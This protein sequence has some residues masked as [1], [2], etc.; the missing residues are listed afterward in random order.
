MK[1]DEEMRCTVHKYDLSGMNALN[2]D[3]CVNWLKNVKIVI[4]RT[5]HCIVATLFLLCRDIIFL[6]HDKGF[7]SL[8]CIAENYVA[9]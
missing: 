5:M 3:L 1:L 8:L 4:L 2:A 6:Y 9:T 7:P